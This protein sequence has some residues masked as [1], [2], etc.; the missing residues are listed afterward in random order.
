LFAVPFA[1]F[2]IGIALNQSVF[3]A[4][5]GK[6][7]VMLNDRLAAEYDGQYGMLD[8]SHCLMT[9]GTHLNW[10]SDYIKLYDRVSSPGDLIIKLSNLLLGYAPI[11]WMTLL[12]ND[13]L[14]GRAKAAP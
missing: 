5:G 4:N 8:E 1:I 14:T 12:V 13:A 6:F 7:P 9:S 11:V 3:I 2:A 10:L